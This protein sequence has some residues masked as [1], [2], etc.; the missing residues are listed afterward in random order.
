M[1]QEPRFRLETI[2]AF[3]FEIISH[4]LAFQQ[5]LI[6]RRRRCACKIDHVQLAATFFEYSS[7]SL[8]EELYENYS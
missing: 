8:A 6:V 4:S 2:L 3:F 5:L 7:S 1:R